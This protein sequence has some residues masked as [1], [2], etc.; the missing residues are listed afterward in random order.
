MNYNI[1]INCA[2]RVY[3]ILSFQSKVKSK[4]AILY[5]LGVNKT[6]NTRISAKRRR[7]ERKIHPIIFN[8]L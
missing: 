2:Q 8:D 7:E 6:E 3:Y 4:E 1:R 5:W